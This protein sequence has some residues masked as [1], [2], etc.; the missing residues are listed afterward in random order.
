MSVTAEFRFVGM[1]PALPHLEAEAAAFNTMCFTCFC[2]T[3]SNYFGPPRRKG[4]SGSEK[5]P[6]WGS[7]R[8][9]SNFGFFYFRS[10]SRRT[11]HQYVLV[12]G[13]FLCCFHVW[14][15]RKSEQPEKQFQEIH[16][17]LRNGDGAQRGD[18][19]FEIAVLRTY[20]L[21]CVYWFSYRN[22]YKPVWVYISGVAP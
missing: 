3:V 1:R 17:T 6:G 10:N 22:R 8:K 19:K 12:R 14:C 11:Y 15:V 20:D 2:M 21:I 9:R 7:F 5:V 18:V 4:W 13:L 16:S